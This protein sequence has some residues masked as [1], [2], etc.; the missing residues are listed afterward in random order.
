MQLDLTDMMKLR[1][2]LNIK[3]ESNFKN[4]YKVLDSIKTNLETELGKIDDGQ[5]NININIVEV[6][7]KESVKDGKVI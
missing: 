7:V 2:E 3:V 4:I 1:F 5:T 6:S